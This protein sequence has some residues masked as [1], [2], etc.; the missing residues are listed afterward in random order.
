M[1]VTRGDTSVSVDPTSLARKSLLGSC[2]FPRPWKKMSS[3]CTKGCP[4]VAGT[5]LSIMGTSC[6]GSDHFCVTF[7]HCDVHSAS[8]R[9]R[10]IVSSSTLK[11]A[12]PSLASLRAKGGSG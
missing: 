5:P 10:Y 1:T 7:N 12:L 4:T 6:F 9:S 11:R 8:L 3:P 2:A